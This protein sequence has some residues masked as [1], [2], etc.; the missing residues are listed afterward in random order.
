V[1]T[2]VVDTVCTVDSVSICGRYSIQLNSSGTQLLRNSTPQEILQ[3]VPEELRLEMVIR[4]EIKVV[5]AKVPGLFSNGSF[6]K[7]SQTILQDSDFHSDE[8]FKF[9]LLGNV[10]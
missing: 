9:H 4:M 2:F 10:L 5:C 3:P 7:R 6:E 8:D 1:D